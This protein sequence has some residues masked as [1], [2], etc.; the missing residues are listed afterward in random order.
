[1]RSDMFKVIVERP[2][3]GKGWIPK[4][5]RRR[6]DFDGPSHAGMRAGVGRPHLNE[7]LSPL[8]RY[9]YKQVG[10]PWDKVWSEI[11]ANIDRRSTVQRHIYQHIDDFIAV[12]V[13]WKN[14]AWSN[15][16]EAG[17]TYFWR[18]LSMRQPLYVDPRTGLIRKNEEYDGW[19]RR[20]EQHAATRAAEIATRLRRLG[21]GRWHLK[22]DSEW[23]EVQMAT[24]PPDQI[25]ERSAR[26]HWRNQYSAA[27]VFDVVLGRP[28]GQHDQYGHNPLAAV[29]G[30]PELYA[31]SKRQL[32][33][34]E[35][36]KYGLPR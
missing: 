9:L 10:R 30:S 22:I 2:R 20:A 36:A 33:R 13:E 3:K 17:R 28:V 5:T 24:L 29:Y 15:Q 27:R 7:N 12:D 11:A 1:M 18:D 16:R 23:Y 32:S 35:I 8:K 26:D 6:I 19:R 25:V 31:V 34:R 4:G 21:D 14:G